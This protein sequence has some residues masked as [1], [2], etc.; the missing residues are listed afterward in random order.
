MAESDARVRSSLVDRARSLPDKVATLVSKEILHGRYG[1]GSKLPTERELSETYGVSRPIIR[2]AIGRLK[3]DG[4][5]IGRQ[6]AGVF[7]ADNGGP[8]I[9]RLDIPRLEDLAEIG[10]VIELL[11]VIE[12]GATEHAA[13]R[14]SKKQLMKIKAACDAMQ[15]AIEGRHSGV[16]ED[17][18]FHRAIAEA[19]RNP[20]F[21]DLDAFLY[22]RVRK[23]ISTARANTAKV[24]GLSEDVQLEHEAIYDA[25]VR[26]DAEE[27]RRA[28]EQHLKNAAER[29]KIYLENQVHSGKEH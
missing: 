16:E 12:A 24:P 22:P 20:Y 25:I 8:A 18:A 4:L 29:L 7:V 6:G 21:S 13:R 27:A 15:S 17:I 9:L 1:P 3:H 23:F 2:E 26:Q 14:R 28:A 19:S 10:S 11:I 5:V